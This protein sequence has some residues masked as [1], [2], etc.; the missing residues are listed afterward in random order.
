[1]GLVKDLGVLF[2]NW[3]DLESN[4]ENEVLFYDFFR[5]EEGYDPSIPSSSARTPIWRWPRSCRP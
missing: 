3:N 5:R 4:L 1:M 2:R